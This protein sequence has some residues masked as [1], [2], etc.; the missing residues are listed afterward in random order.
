MKY[1]NGYL[2]KIA[3]HLLNGNHEKAMYFMHRQTEVY[4]PITKE[5]VDFIHYYVITGGEVQAA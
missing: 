3:Y 1:P 2:N 4:G 5:Q